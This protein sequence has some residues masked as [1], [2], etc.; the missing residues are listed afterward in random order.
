MATPICFSW[1]IVLAWFAFCRMLLVVMMPSTA[2]TAMM[3]IT[4]RTSIKVKARLRWKEVGFKGN[5]WWVVDAV[6]ITGGPTARKRGFQA[7]HSDSVMALV[8]LNL[9]RALGYTQ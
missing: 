5:K 7:G 6:E 3:A 1:F 2:N 4:T 9:F 8:G